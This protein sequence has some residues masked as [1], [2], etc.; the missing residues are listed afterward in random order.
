MDVLL[1]CLR[2]HPGTEDQV[3]SARPIFH[4]ILVV[5]AR[6]DYVSRQVQFVAETLMNRLKVTEVVG[7]RRIFIFS[8]K[9]LKLLQKSTDIYGIEWKDAFQTC[10]TYVYNQQDVGVWVMVSEWETAIAT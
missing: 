1:R 6:P 10:L 2:I 9:M 5:G 3:E 8:W 4:V 7:D